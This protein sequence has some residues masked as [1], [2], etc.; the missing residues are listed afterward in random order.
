MSFDEHTLKLMEDYLE[1]RL[2]EE[3][4]H[5]FEKELELDSDFKKSFSVYKKMNGFYNEESWYLSKKD[6][7]SLE[8]IKSIYNETEFTVFANR[9]E[10]FK[11]KRKLKLK[12]KILYITSIAAAMALLI[13]SGNYF[14]TDSLSTS[15]LYT[16]YYSENDLPSLTV[17]DDNENTLAKAEYLYR[18]QNYMEALKLFKQA[19][20]DQYNPKLS[21]YLALS[22]SALN[23]YGDA[24][25][26]LDTLQQ[27]STIDSDKAYWF[28]ALIYLKQDNREKSIEYLNR[29]TKDPT[30]FNYDK[31]KELL[32]KLK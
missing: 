14:F 31:A 20:Q 22:Y 7:I 19:E 11:Q 16:T 9:L 29:L 26:E 25:M 4:R 28:K 3:E 8:N 23:K 21:I 12:R 1:N 6:D 27:S 18:K 30:N 13:I 24:L 5:T 17:Q 2:S 32:L 15:E 10:E